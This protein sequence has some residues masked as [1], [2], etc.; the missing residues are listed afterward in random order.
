MS[1]P[2]QKPPRRPRSE[3][4]R[5]RQR[6]IP[7]RWKTFR[8][9]PTVRGRLWISTRIRRTLWLWQPWAVLGGWFLAIDRYWWAL[10][11]LGLAAVAYVLRWPE[12][13]PT[14]GLDH[15][16][17]VGGREFLDTV[18]GLTGIEFETGNSL[19]VLENG[20]AFYPSMLDAIGRAQRSITMEQY[21][22]WAG[23][24]GEAFARALAGRARAGVPVKLLLDAVG[25]ATLGDRALGILEDGGCEVAWY[26]EIHW[27]TVGRFNNRT[28]RKTLVA[29]GR[30]GFT[31]GAGIADHWR[32]DARSPDEWRDTQVRVEGPAVRLLQTGFAQNWLRAT[33]A[34]V[35][36][37]AFFPPAVPAGPCDLQVISSSP[38]AGSSAARL[39]YYLVIVSA[40]RRIDIANPYFVP[41]ETAVDTL[42]EAAARGVQVRVLV[43]GRRNDNWLARQ[44]SVRLY[45]VLLDGGVQVHE[46]HRTML[47]QK[48]MI[49]DECWCTVGTTN[50]DS[51]SFAHNEETNVCTCDERAVQGL[52]RTFEADLAAS[53]PVTAEAWRRRG[54]LARAQELVASMLQDQ[55]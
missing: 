42:T 43:T 7:R 36:G 41:D 22:F 47:H 11:A 40:R 46:Y 44:N 28:H 19:V 26:N 1:I 4:R 31:G 32:G 54:A 23:E 30:V 55:V 39:M 49:V 5:F 3:P 29:D 21:I 13:P 18:A 50:F 8:P 38:D 20:D 9:P 27:F 10:A 2:G 14:V 45:G 17:P 16:T 12:R 15:T 35:Q 33:G 48:V 6:P 51:R 52:T 25:S 24:T 37:E 53:A 34:V